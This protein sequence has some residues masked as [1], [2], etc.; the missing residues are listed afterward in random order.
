MKIGS[1][2]PTILVAST[3]FA[4]RTSCREFDDYVLTCILTP[5][6]PVPTALDAN[7]VYPYVS[8]VETSNRPLL[9]K[10]HFVVLENNYMRVTICPDLGSK[11]S[12]IVLKPSGMEVLYQP[13][14]VRYTRILP[15]FYFTAGGIEVSFPISHSPSE[16]EK[17]SYRVDGNSERTYVTCGER[18]LR[19]GMQYSIEFSLGK[20][21]NFLT[22]RVVY[23]NPGTKPYPWMSWSNAALPSAHD[24][25]Y[26]FPRGSVLR[27]ASVID[28]I[29]WQT[30]GPRTESEIKEMTGYFW[31]TKDANAFG[32]FTSSIGTGLFHIADEKIAPGMKLW[33]Y[34]TGV[35]TLWA[36][37]SSASNQTY[38]E[39]QGGPLQDQSIKIE[40]GPDQTK[41]HVEYWIP[42]NRP[43][44]IYGL[45]LPVPALRPIADVPMFEWARQREVAI[46]LQMDLAYKLNGKLPAPPAVDENLWAPSGL[47]HLDS[48]FQFAIASSNP[49]NADLWKFYYG[50]W[51][52]GR[53]RQDDAIRILSS[54]DVGIAKVLLARLLKLEGKNAAAKQAFESISELWLQLH[55]QVVVERD[56]LLRSI[57]KQTLSER[58]EWL[59]K[60]DALK[61][62]GLIERRIQ[63]LIDQGNVQQAKNLLLG[64]TWQKVH[65]TYTRTGLWRQICEK[66]FINYLPIPQQLGED[67]LA[68]F[69][70][71]RE[72]E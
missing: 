21:D 55:P 61:D 43:L 59:D 40:L 19:F 10:Y 20:E 62:E 47:E 6:G 49:G 60:V 68:R 33:S 56:K 18:E 4:Q 23:H 58:Q 36:V 52:A 1:L 51:L 26:F 11:V 2:L 25:K 28:T 41:W 46:W 54:C 69:G 3:C 34:G 35:D 39:L 9:K 48:P 17:L 65:Q 5:A 53:D 64:T 66:M 24:T 44:D 72:Y 27:H 57:G 45:K 37:Q 50:S 30:Q 7:G 15:R 32:A 67:R 29:D 63:L 16:N 42:S 22:E 31:R 70:A 13:G 12:S 38:V 14:L 8:Y 71:Y